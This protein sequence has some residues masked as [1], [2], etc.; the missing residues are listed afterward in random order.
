MLQWTW[1]CICLFKLVFLLSSDRCP[2]VEELNHMVVLF[3][4][5]LRKL[6]IIFFVDQTSLH[7]HQCCSGILFSSY[8]SK[9]LISFVTWVIQFLPDVTLV[10][11]SLRSSDVE[12]LFM[13]L[14]VIC[15]SLGKSLFQSSVHFSSIR[16]WWWWLL[17][18]MRSLYN[19]DVNHSLEI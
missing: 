3:L 2:G 19:L 1:R 15:L 14:L 8:P 4:I 13:C 9:Q 16:W 5:F 12:R 11:L 6:Y 10:F 17:S 7:S 18:C